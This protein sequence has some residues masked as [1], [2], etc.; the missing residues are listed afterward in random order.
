VQEVAFP[1]ETRRLVLRPVTANDADALQAMY[2]DWQVARWLSRLP[3]PFTFSFACTMAADAVA[4]N[5]P[6]LRERLAACRS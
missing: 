5:K 6:Y 1:F 2:N 3:W 4:L